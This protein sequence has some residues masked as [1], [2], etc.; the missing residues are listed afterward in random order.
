MCRAAG[1]SAQLMAKEEKYATLT[2]A[3]RRNEIGSDMLAALLLVRLVT[4]DHEII[5][6]GKAGR[7]RW[8]GVRPT[9]PWCL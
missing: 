4:L 6:V 7:T 2:Y 9:V 5:N 8:M 1:T 3:I